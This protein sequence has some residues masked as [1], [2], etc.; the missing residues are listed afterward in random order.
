MEKEVLAFLQKTYPD[1][2]FG[3][4]ALIDDGIVDSL[5]LVEM[6]SSLSLEYGVM[7]PYEEIIPENFNSAAAIAALIKKL[8]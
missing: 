2:D 1:I 3:S 7:I 5:V 8:K 4:E 6:I